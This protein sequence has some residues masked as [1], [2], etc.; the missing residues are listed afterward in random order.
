MERWY[1][2][3]LHS[4]METLLLYYPRI[5]FSPWRRSQMLKQW[6]WNWQLSV[7]SLWRLKECHLLLFHCRLFFFVL[8]KLSVLGYYLPPSWLMILWQAASSSAFAVVL[9]VTQ[10]TCPWT[11]QT[12]GPHVFCMLTWT[13]TQK[14]KWKPMHSLRL[15]SDAEV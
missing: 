5:F 12:S 1:S 15:M 11:L 3:F 8:N 7:Q 14:Y 6:S 2:H 4:V 9:R 13:T 10:A